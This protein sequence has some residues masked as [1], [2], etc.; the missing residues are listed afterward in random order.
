MVSWNCN[1]GSGC[2][3]SESSLLFLHAQL[4]H[5][6]W[7]RLSTNLFVFRERL[8]HFSQSKYH[9]RYRVLFVH[10]YVDH[11]SFGRV[12]TTY[13]SLNIRSHNRIQ[14]QKLWGTLKRTFIELRVEY[15]VPPRHK[16]RHS[17]KRSATY[18][19]GTC[20]QSKCHF[21]FARIANLAS[22][23]RV[24][25]F[26]SKVVHSASYAHRFTSQ[27]PMNSRLVCRWQTWHLENPQ[28]ASR[29]S[30]NAPCILGRWSS[31][32]TFLYNSKELML[33][34]LKY[35]AQMPPVSPFHTLPG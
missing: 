35:T 11:Q 10:S 24:F 29:R 21:H 14:W 5:L 18:R 1:H 19:D 16:Y 28:A 4:L 7:F 2:R 23:R 30:I 34:L 9:H 13:M 6:F 20:M 3:S 15:L 25:H 26:V 17:F 27:V 8:R 31:F 33:S 12:H 22:I 32:T